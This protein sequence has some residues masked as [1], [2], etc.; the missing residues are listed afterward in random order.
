[1]IREYI[2]YI[3]KAQGRHQIHSPYVYDFVDV[4]LQQVLPSNIKRELKILQEELNA[5]NTKVDLLDL[6][7]GSKRRK[8]IN[9]VSTI[10]K[11]SASKGTYFNLLYQLSNHYQSAHI[12]EL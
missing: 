7:A 4:C 12:L 9:T 8:S 3:R 1:M 11:N 2:K 10:Y 5:N 6:G